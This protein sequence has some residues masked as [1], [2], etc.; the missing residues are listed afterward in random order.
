LRTF[1]VTFTPKIIKIDF[2][3]SELWRDK[4]MTIGIQ[5][6]KTCLGGG[7]YCPTVLYYFSNKIIDRG[8]KLPDNILNIVSYT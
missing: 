5:H 7:M 6:S 2:C 3:L 8:N 1:S 4:V